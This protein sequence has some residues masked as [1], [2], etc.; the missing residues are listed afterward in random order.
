[1]IV[2]PLVYINICPSEWCVCAELFS[3]PKSN[4]GQLGWHSP[5]GNAAENVTIE[6]GSYEKSFFFTTTKNKG[7][8]ILY[9]DGCLFQI[10]FHVHMYTD[11][12]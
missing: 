9:I 6:T 8:I 10:E 12:V 1:M 5:V 2:G 7:K 11:V 4:W 3:Y